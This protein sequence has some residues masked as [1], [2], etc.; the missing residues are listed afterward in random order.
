MFVYTFRSSKL[1]WLI[2]AALCVVAVVAFVCFSRSSKPAAQDGAIVLKAATTEE[3]MSFVSQFGWQVQPD[4][5]QVEEVLIPLEFDETYEAYNGIQ[6]QQNLDL[7]LYAG[8]RVKRWSYTVTNYPG[9]EGRQDVIRLN[10]LVYE[11]MVI[12]GDVCSLEKDGFIHGFDRPTT[13]L[14]K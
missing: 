7:S 9:Y 10:M 8:K 12:G 4:P 11:G 3:R 6:K 14:P 2:P 5:A 13:P 1:K